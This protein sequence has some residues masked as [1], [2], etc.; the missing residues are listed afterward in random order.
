MIVELP[1]AFAE[2]QIKAVVSILAKNLP[3][4]VQPGIQLLQMDRTRKEAGDFYDLINLVKSI[5]PSDFHIEVHAPIC[6]HDPQLDLNLAN[7][8]STEIILA[9]A[10]FAQAIGAETLI[11]HTN[12]VYYPTAA[13]GRVLATVWEE[14]NNDFN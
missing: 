7:P 3:S 9:N 10:F 5:V 2:E 1:S 12:T 14:C 6:P 4:C 11:V 13:P 8:K